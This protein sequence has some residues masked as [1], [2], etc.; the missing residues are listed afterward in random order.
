MQNIDQ[1]ISAH[2]D[3]ER[4]PYWLGAATDNFLCSLR[5]TSAPPPAAPSMRKEKYRIFLSHPK[6]PCQASQMRFFLEPT[7]Q[8]RLQPLAWQANDFGAKARGRTRGEI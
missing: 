5:S 7:T 8:G 1:V 3:L 2:D 4:R 6:S